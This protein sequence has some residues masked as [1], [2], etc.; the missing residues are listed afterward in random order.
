M[1]KYVRSTVFILFT[2]MLLKTFSVSWKHSLTHFQNLDL[3]QENRIQFF[4]K[5]YLKN[6]NQ[7]INLS[8]GPIILWIAKQKTIFKYLYQTTRNL[9]LFLF[10]QFL[11]NK[12]VKKKKRSKVIILLSKR[13]LKKKDMWNLRSHF[14]IKNG[15]Y[16]A[17]I[18]Q[19]IKLLQQYYYLNGEEKLAIQKKYW[20]S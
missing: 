20:L 17:A 12:I 14:F 18:Y 11:I 19:I 16:E 7:T 1:N 13:G 8:V 5:L 6:I 15:K 3:N 10:S 4:G 2:T 9:S